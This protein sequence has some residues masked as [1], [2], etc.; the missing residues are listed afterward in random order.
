M[1][2]LSAVAPAPGAFVFDEAAG[3]T[4]CA[5]ATPPAAWESPIAWQRLSLPTHPNVLTFIGRPSGDPRTPTTAAGGQ[6]HQCPLWSSKDR[7][8]GV[9]VVLLSCE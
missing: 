5:F 4:V 6:A 7:R 8:N 1:F 2:A 3:L 9:F